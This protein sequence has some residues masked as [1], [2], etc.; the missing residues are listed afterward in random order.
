MIASAFS[1]AVR[2]QNDDNA[3]PP[4]SC[5]AFHGRNGSRLCV[6]ITCGT[7]C[8]S[9]ALCPAKL[10]YQVWLCT[11]SVPDA[12]A[13]IAKSIPMVRSAALAPASSTGSG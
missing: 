13:A 2:S 5:S 4:P 6:V 1:I 12:P 11:M 7:S 8:S 10:A 9:L 3:Y